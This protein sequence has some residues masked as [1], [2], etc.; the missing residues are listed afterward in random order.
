[1]GLAIADKLTQAGHRVVL[2]G[3]N[4]N[5]N[6]C[7]DGA[8]DMIPLTWGELDAAGLAK[9]VDDLVGRVRKVDILVFATDAPRT[10]R[11]GATPVESLQSSD[12]NAVVLENLTAAFLVVKAYIPRM[13]KQRW[14]RVVFVVPEEVR[15]RP[16]GAGAHFIAAK[17]GLIGLARTLVHEVGPDQVTVNCVAAGSASGDHK[18]GGRHASLQPPTTIDAA[19]AVAFLVSEGA[20]FITGTTLDVNGGRTM[21]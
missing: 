6:I 5:A 2:V 12:W 3:D 16:N 18:R 9:S 14:G 7:S 8:T 4:V 21:L 20:S 13:Q 15:A 11:H 1:M 19:E 17:A 10:G